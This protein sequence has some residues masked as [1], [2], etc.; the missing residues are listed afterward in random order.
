MKPKPEYTLAYTY[1][2]DGG[3]VGFNHTGTYGRIRYIINHDMNI[4]PEHNRIIDYQFFDEDG[5]TCTYF[6]AVMED[7]E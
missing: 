3:V 5:Y 7:D 6:D 4:D 1:R 2:Q